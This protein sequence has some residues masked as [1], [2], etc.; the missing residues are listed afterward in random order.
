MAVM[1]EIK[2][3][4]VFHDFVRHVA[5]DATIQGRIEK[6]KHIGVEVDAFVQNPPPGVTIPP[7]IGRGSDVIEIDPAHT[8]KN[9]VMSRQVNDD[10][11]IMVLPKP[12]AFSDPLPAGDYPLPDFYSDIAFDGAP[13]NIEDSEKDRFRKM[14]IGEYVLQQCH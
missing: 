7:A 9:I 2:D 14:R 1:F 13:E 10:D 8:E 12:T 4:E 6:L 3:Y 11:V 5:N